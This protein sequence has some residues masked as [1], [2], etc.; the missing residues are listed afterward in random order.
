MAVC[1]VKAGLSGEQVTSK[2]TDTQTTEQT[3]SNDDNYRFQGVD[4]TIDHIET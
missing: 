4:R 3:T 1:E 2:S